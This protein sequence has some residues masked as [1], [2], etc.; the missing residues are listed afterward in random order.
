MQKR[1]GREKIFFEKS[2][3]GIEIS[4]KHAKNANYLNNRLDLK[5]ALTIRLKS[6]DSSRRWIGWKV[7]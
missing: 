4:K 6:S 2:F 3:F 1:R 7:F 5:A